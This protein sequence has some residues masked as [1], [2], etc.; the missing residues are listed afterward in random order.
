MC[1]GVFSS[2]LESL[3]CWL[4]FKVLLY[5]T[6]GISFPSLFGSHFKIKAGFNKDFALSSVQ[7]SELGSNTIKLRCGFLPSASAATRPSQPSSVF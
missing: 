7:V 3:V 2:Q 5:E 6:K 1:T 4:D